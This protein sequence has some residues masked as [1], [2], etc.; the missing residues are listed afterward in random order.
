MASWDIQKRNFLT[1]RDNLMNNTSSSSINNLV[2]TLNRNIKEFTNNAGI[3]REANYVGARNTFDNLIN[4][5]KDFNG[6]N[7][8]LASSV[9]QISASGDI[10]S[11]LRTQ[12]ELQQSI[13]N[14][15]KEL[16]IAKKDADISKTREDSVEKSQRDISYYQGFSS[17]LDITRPLKKASI[18]ILIGFG[19][20]CIILSGLILRDFFLPS[21]GLVVDVSG[22]D[23]AGIF[24]FFTDSRFYSVFGSLG[25]VIFVLG[26][27]S[28]RGYFGKSLE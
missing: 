20:L 9:Q 24:S 27:L 4:L 18:P 13:A 12:G 28:Y 26:I 3:N 15:E 7:K 23:S 22:Y 1:E 5:Q 25:F 8:R 21:Q 19:V 10:R 17:Y 11:R 2:D 14:L 16:E 6:L